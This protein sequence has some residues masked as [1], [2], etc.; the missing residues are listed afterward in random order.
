MI[1]T[2]HALE[3]WWM[4]YR[5]VWYGSV[6]SSFVMPVLFLVSIGYGVGSYV[7]STESLGGVDYAAFVAPG[8]LA[9][10][11][12]Q[13]VGGEMTWPVFAALRW[14]QQYKAMQ[15]SP[16]TPRQILSGHLLYGLI[17]VAVTAIVFAVVMAAFGIFSA[18]APLSVVATIGVGYAFIGWVYAFSVSV[19]SETT[20]SIIHR[21]G[22]VPVSLF[23]GVF[24]PLS[25]LPAYL[26]P[27]AWISPLWHGAELSRWAVSGTPTPWPWYLHIAYLLVLG[28]VG[29]WLAGAQLRRRMTS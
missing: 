16:L 4:N 8:L 15:T 1:G 12:L 28:T 18:T 10:T 23:S 9:S 3:Y 29:W 14:G 25:Q 27:L 17:R 21:F 20:L 7:G 11:A 2:L 22:I 26:Q 5:R 19:K 24:F 6:F 13:M